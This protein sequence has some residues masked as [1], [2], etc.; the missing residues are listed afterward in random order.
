[1][2]QLERS[3]TECVTNLQSTKINERKVNYHY[4]IISSFR[5]V[6]ILFIH[7]YLYF[8]EKCSRFTRDNA[9]K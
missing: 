6:F 2:D 7:V 5:L 1:M 9:K 8:T 4:T 3:L